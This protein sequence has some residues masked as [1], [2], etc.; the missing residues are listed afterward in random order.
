M[1]LMLK[2]WSLT[3]LRFSLGS[4]P[5]DPLFGSLGGEDVATGCRSQPDQEPDVSAWVWCCRWFFGWFS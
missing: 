3:A 2:R 1:F 5:E 4:S